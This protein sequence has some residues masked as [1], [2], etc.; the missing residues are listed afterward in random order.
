VI[1]GGDKVE[2]DTAY[3]YDGFAHFGLRLRIRGF[4]EILRPARN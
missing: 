4:L 1:G 2:I 3:Y